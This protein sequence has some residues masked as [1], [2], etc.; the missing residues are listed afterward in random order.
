[1]AKI[2]F[3]DGN[4]AIKPGILKALEDDGGMGLGVLFKELIEQFL[5]GVQLG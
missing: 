4:F 3:E 5:I 1:M 2:I